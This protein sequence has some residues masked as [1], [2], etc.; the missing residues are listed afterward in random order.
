ML[1]DPNAVLEYGVD[2]SKWLGDDTIT[3]ATWDVTGAD[4]DSESFDDTTTTVWLSGGI[5]GAPIKATNHI[6]T[7]GGREDDRTLTISV[8]ER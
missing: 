5:T 3:N 1:K 6:V 7:A 2:W 8:R 4:V